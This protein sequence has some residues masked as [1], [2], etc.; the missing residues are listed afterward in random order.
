MAVPVCML[1]I[2]IT[3]RYLHVKE[4]R[5]GLQKNGY[6]RFTEGSPGRGLLVF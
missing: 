2:I 3:Y 6:E 4:K 1:I 5:E